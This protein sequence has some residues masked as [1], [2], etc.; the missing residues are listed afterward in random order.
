MEYKELLGTRNNF[1]IFRDQ[2][3]IFVKVKMVKEKGARC[4]YD[5]LLRKLSRAHG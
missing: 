5:A 2:I 3:K 4:N 1:H